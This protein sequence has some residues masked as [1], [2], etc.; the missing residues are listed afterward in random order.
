[1]QYL[2]VLYGNMRKK[3]EQLRESEMMELSKNHF[4]STHT[5]K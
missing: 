4:L 5:Q 1:M 3:M 2:S